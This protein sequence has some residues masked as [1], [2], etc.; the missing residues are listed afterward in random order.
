MFRLDRGVLIYLFLC[1]AAGCTSTLADSRAGL[2]AGREGRARG[3]DA[4]PR[5]SAESGNGRGDASTAS[6]EGARRDGA[7]ATGDWVAPFVDGSDAKRDASAEGSLSVDAGLAADTATDSAPHAAPDSAPLDQG[8]AVDSRRVIDLSTDSV[9]ASTGSISEIRIAGLSTRGAIIRW[10]TTQVADGR[11]H[12]GPTR[13]YGSSVSEG[14]STKDHYVFLDKLEPNTS[15]HYQVQSAGERSRDLSFKTPAKV[16]ELWPVIS[17]SFD[18]GHIS[19]YKT[20]FPLLRARNMRGMVNVVT[21]RVARGNNGLTL[22]QLQLLQRKGWEIGSH[23]R[24]HFDDTSLR[25]QDEIAGSKAYLEQNGIKTVVTY[26]VPGAM[27]SQTREDYAAQYYFFRWGGVIGGKSSPRSTTLPL[28]SGIYGTVNLN[29]INTTSL[30]ERVA[31]YK[32]YI[33]KMLSQHHYVHVN[34]HAIM[35][36]P[37]PAYNYPPAEFAAFLDYLQSKGIKVI[38]PRE[39]A[40]E[41]F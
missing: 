10:K 31:I 11:V 5:L 2:D 6:G 40:A 32:Q 35:D 39:L 13:A 34:L 23:S 28:A 18:D 27:H 4:A 17:I 37:T 8:A 29:E 9:L 33:E 36:S 26:R 22:A 19:A 21:D 16:E 30:Q 25:W 14:E 20:A 41:A 15:Y 24:S 38:P 7:G 1:G 12:Y 3:A